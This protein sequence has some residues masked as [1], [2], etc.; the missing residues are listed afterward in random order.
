MRI[1][2]PDTAGNVL[3]NEYYLSLLLFFIY[4]TESN[5]SDSLS[6]TLGFAITNNVQTHSVLAKIIPTLTTIS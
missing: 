3:L 6:L 2:I 4:L 5:L 1:P